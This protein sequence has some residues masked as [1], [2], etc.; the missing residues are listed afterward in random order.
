[1]TTALVATASL[2]C[3][4]D[5]ETC[6]HGKHPHYAEVT[7]SFDWTDYEGKNELPDSMYVVA[8]RVVN[9]WKASMAVNAKSGIGHC[10]YNEYHGS[11]KDDNVG[12]IVGAVDKF[13]IKTG[14]YKFI[15][16]SLDTTEFNAENVDEFLYSQAPYKHIHDVYLT[17]KSYKID[18]PDLRGVVA[19]WEDYNPYTDFIQPDIHP[20]FFDSLLT[21]D[22]ALNTV[23]ACDFRPKRITQDID[24][25]FN[26]K[27]VPGEKAIPFKI[28]SVRAE[29]SG[30]PHKIYLSNG[31]FDLAHTKKMM[32]SPEMQDMNGNVIPDG[33]DTYG[34]NGTIRCHKLISVPTIMHN[35]NPTLVSGPGMMQVLIF[36]SADDPVLGH[37]VKKVQGIINLHNTLKAA[38]LIELTSDGKNVFRKKDF[39]TLDIKATM[40]MTGESILKSADN[41]DGL[42]SWVPTDSDDLDFDI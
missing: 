12:P 24:I 5:V 18:N 3:T 20:I 34:C 38:D 13:N 21:R 7:Y 30:I 1:M 27:K 6:T 8:Y 25:Y 16:F 32:F 33:E 42:D 10:L 40:E 19:G 9:H 4:T 14:A 28:D 23:T 29:I 35:D 41:E 31:Y 39:A 15:A 2:S 17:Y 11:I 37:R 26:I 36:L 22:I